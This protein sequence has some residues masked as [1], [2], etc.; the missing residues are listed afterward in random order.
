MRRRAITEMG[1]S[2]RRRVFSAAALMFVS[3]ACSALLPST[4]EFTLVFTS[5][6]TASRQGYTTDGIH[7]FTSDTAALYKRNN[8]EHWSIAAQNRQPFVGLFGRPNHLGDL[9]YHEG[10]LFV[11]VEQFLHPCSFEDQQLAVYDAGSL[12]LITSVDVSAQGAEVS[13]VVVVPE[14]NMLYVNSF[15]EGSRLWKYEM[16]SL[17]FVGT[18]ALSRPIP[19]L[20]GLA[21]DGSRFFASSS[22]DNRVYV[23]E[24][25][26]RVR[27]PVIAREGCEAEGL[28]WYDGTLRW[29]FN[30]TGQGGLCQGVL[31][32]FVYFY[33]PSVRQQQ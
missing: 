15:C 19:N 6:E 27:G 10:K 1:S 24:S 14:E 13:G 4:E 17:S 30:Q 9:D 12:S 22:A 8:D 31:S 11:P 21:W 25:N 5:P 20:Q 3:V 7:H 18:L 26:G 29:S 16:P 2:R 33:R 28:K 32:N 23:I